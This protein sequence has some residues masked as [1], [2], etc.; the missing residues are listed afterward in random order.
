[1]RALLPGQVWL[2]A[3]G[4]IRD[5]LV[6]AS[7]HEAQRTVE[8]SFRPGQVVL[9]NLRTEETAFALEPRGARGTVLIDLP[10]REG[11]KPLFA[12]ES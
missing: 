12:V 4:R 9:R 10:R 3:F 2:L 7:G 11:A 1:M 6:T 5:V 8:A